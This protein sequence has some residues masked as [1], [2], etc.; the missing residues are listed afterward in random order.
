MEHWKT[1]AKQLIIQGVSCQEFL[2]EMIK[3]FDWSKL[4]YNVNLLEGFGY[5][6]IA[7]AKTIDNQSTVGT[8]MLCST[9]Q[10]A[11]KKAIMDLIDKIYNKLGFKSKHILAA[12][13][14]NSINKN[15]NFRKK[16]NF[17]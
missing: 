2:H 6:C 5:T 16:K 17:S 15:Y 3:Y 7:W 1:F 8:A 4:Y 12:L 11:I 14:V 13:E 10:E 9:E